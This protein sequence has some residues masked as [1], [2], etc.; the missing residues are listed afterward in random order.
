MKLIKNP[1]VYSTKELI[2]DNKIEIYKYTLT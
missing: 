2:T 1:F